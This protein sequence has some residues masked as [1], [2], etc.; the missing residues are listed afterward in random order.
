MAAIKLKD[1]LFDGKAERNGRAREDAKPQRREV[2]KKCTC[3]NHH[4]I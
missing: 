1:G 4:L 2:K 3:S